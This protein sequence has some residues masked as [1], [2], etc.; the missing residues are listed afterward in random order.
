MPEKNP[1]QVSQQQ[2]DECAKIMG[3]SPSTLAI[4]RVPRRELHISLPVKM[5]DG[6]VKVFEGFRV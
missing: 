1:F 6:S 3:L 2:L 5:D 4:L